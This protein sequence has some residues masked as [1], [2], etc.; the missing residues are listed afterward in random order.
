MFTQVPTYTIDRVVEPGPGGYFRAP[1]LFF[2]LVL[3]GFCKFL[4][5]FDFRS[6]TSLLMQRRLLY[7]NRVVLRQT[8]FFI[9]RL[10]SSVLF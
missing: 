7:K 2:A 5:C 9:R 4:S 6:L 8:F 3:K 1:H 10:D